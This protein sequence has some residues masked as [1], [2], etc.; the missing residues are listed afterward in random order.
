MRVPNGQIPVAGSATRFIDGAVR[1]RFECTIGDSPTQM[2]SS[3]RCWRNR[4]LSANES[5]HVV[6]KDFPFCSIGV[7]NASIATSEFAENVAFGSINHQ[8]VKKKNQTV[9]S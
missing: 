8:K 5:V 1:V 6:V 2:L 3:K 4:N 7:S 9:K